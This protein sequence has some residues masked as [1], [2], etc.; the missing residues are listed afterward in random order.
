MVVKWQLVSKVGCPDGGS[1]RR[2]GRQGRQGSDRKGS[3]SRLC[4]RR[5]ALPLSDSS[6]ACDTIRCDMIW[7]DAIRYGARLFET[8]GSPFFLVLLLAAAAGSK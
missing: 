5:M 4:A 7:Y 8:G 3:D 1:G 6:S 2:Q